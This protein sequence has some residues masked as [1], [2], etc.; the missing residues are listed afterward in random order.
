[1]VLNIGRNS[2]NDVVISDSEVSG[3]HAQIVSDND[4]QVFIND[5]NSQNGTFVNGNKI[6]QAKLK[7][8]DVIGAGEILLTFHI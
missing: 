4:N 5:L 6:S 3:H 8:G 1:M 7:H 2:K